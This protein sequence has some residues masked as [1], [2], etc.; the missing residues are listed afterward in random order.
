MK[1]VKDALKRVHEIAEKKGSHVIHTSEISRND[2]LLLIKQHWLDEII[3]GWYLLV[4]PDIP[5]GDSTAW[6]ANFW[7]F[8]KIY[9]HFHYGS[10]YC[11]SAEC[12]L[13]VHLGSTVI[14]KQLIIMA[15]KGSGK[16][17]QLPHEVSLL[18][19]A[20]SSAL[21]E[22][23]EEIRGLQIMTLPYAL[24][25]VTPT[26]YQ[27]SPQE[28]EIALRSLSSTSDLMRVILNYN[29]K[30][31]AE[32][33]I[34]AYQHLGDVERAR[35]LK[36]SL[37]DMGFT[38]SEKNP[39]TEQSIKVVNNRFVSPHVARIHMMWDKLRP[40][41]IAHF[42][43]PPGL[44][45]NAEEYLKQVAKKYA[46]DAYNSLSIE[47]YQVT[48]EL[49]EKVMKAEW[50][51][52][53]SFQDHQQNDALAARG[54]YE[55]HLLVK[56][57]V[58]KILNGESPG[59]VIQNDLPLW[60]RKLFSPSVQAGILKASDLFGYRRNQVYIRQSRHT[61]PAKEHL[62]HLMEVLFERLKEE[63]HAGVRA[64]LGHFI[65]VYIHPYMDGNGRI[66]RFLMNA[67]LASGGYPWTIVHV[68]YRSQ[69]ITALETASTV[70]DI[71][72]F[73]EFIASE[74]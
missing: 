4:R 7:D 23:R 45:K 29:F 15:L 34:G 22:E 66:G 21:P 69:Y 47:G 18:V 2:R 5:G 72:P 14:P 27:T 41:V 10:D 52:V 6:Y 68:K 70:G 31:A 44:P 38:L 59:Q 56:S 1:A 74:L 20:T 49:I 16:P 50:S 12:S 36:D 33:L 48:K 30:S 25:K 43:Q 37:L 39:F 60:F 8:L 42:P 62:G 73:T 11:L 65:F 19:Y 46:Q 67:M 35:E 9:L 28:A 71:I 58:E 24:C 53:D 26:Y 61:P 55:A 40:V 57:S 63:E 54:Y 17:L 13:D 51:P 32:R 64:I 3:R